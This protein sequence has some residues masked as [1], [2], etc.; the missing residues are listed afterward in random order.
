MDKNARFIE[1]NGALYPLSDVGGVKRKDWGLE[2]WWLSD[3]E[4]HLRINAGDPVLAYA[5]FKAWL[6]GRWREP[7]GA[8]PGN[9]YPF[10]WLLDT[11]TLP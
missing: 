11:E 2:I 4:A 3:L 5:R 9:V 1:Y 10:D 7:W 6:D 8:E